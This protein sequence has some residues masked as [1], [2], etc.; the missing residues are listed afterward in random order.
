MSELHIEISEL[1]AAG[2]NVYDP[3]ETLRVATALGYQLVVRVIECDPTRF[4]S[5]VA[6]WFEQEVVA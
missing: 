5:M 1:I 2:V 6:A 3:E 4:L